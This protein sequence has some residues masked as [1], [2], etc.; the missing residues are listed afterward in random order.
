MPVSPRQLLSVSGFEQSNQTNRTQNVLNHL[1]NTDP[2]DETIHAYSTYTIAEQCQCSVVQHLSRQCLCKLGV[3]LEQLK[4]QQRL[5]GLSA[6]LNSLLQSG[7]C[8]LPSQRYC[9][10]LTALGSPQ[11]VFTQQASLYCQVVIA[12][13]LEQPVTINTALACTSTSGYPSRCSAHKQ[14][15]SLQNISPTGMIYIVLYSNQAIGI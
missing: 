5:L 9:Q 14:R 12:Q 6:V 13:L 10:L 15:S 2:H 4:A 1:C 3:L 11:M 8:C 7:L